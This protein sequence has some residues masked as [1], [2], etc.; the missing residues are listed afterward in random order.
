[1]V[2]RL[3]QNGY[4]Q[5]GSFLGALGLR[6]FFR[7]RRLRKLSHGLPHWQSADLEGGGHV[8]QFY[9]GDFPADSVARFLLD[10]IQAKEVCIVIA[11]PKHV[12]AID[13]LLDRPGKC[14]YL[15][16]R[17]TMAKFMVDGRPDRLRFLDTVGDLVAQ[18]AEAGGHVRAFGEMVVLLCKDGNAEAAREL[19]QLWNEL[20]RR[21]HM[22][23]LC[24]YPI[25]V[26]EGRS[27]G[28]AH[29]LRDTHSHAVA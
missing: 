5:G 26:L 22:R 29:A 14:I 1:M 15:D 3:A 21:H 10:G 19:E 9:G 28:H 24:S 8:V 23:L 27:A 11:D 18:A 16:A 17:E 7:M 25:E 6:S 2:G 20:G 4:G 13:R 12:A